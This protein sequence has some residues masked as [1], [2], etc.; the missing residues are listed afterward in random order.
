MMISRKIEGT[1]RA[2][3]F[4]ACLAV[5]GLFAG[6]TWGQ[7]LS[8]TI[9][10][11]VKDSS[12]AV[13]AGATV[14]VKSLESGQTRTVESETSGDY[15]T[16]ALPVG[17]YQVSAEKMGFKMEI[18]QGITLVVG[19]QAVVNF[20]LEVGNVQQEVTVTA[21]AP[22]INT[23]TSSTSGLVDEQQVKDL[24]L[25]GRSF[26]QLLTLNAGVVNFNA[27]Q[28]IGNAT[29]SASL[30]TVS[31]RRWEENRYLMNGIDYI[32]SDMQGAA[33][34]PF[35]SSGKLLG[36]DAIRE[37]NV[38][39]DAYGA[40]VGKRAGGQVEIATMSGTN[41]LH[42]D[43]FEFVRNNIFDAR[44][45]FDQTASAPPYKRNQ[46]G[47]AL[48]GPIKKDKL[49]VFG[50]YEGYRE[51]VAVST[52]AVVPDLQVR[53]GKL[54]DPATGVYTQLPA[55]P[56]GKPG[57]SGKC[58]FPG[59]AAVMNAYWPVPNG[60]EVMAS[61][62]I[63]PN[64]QVPFG[65]AHYF[66][67]PPFPIRE[68]F[69]LV[70]VDYV[71]SAKDTLSGNLLFD[72]GESDPPGKDPLSFA[73][74]PQRSMLPSL[75]ETHIFSTNLINVANFGVSRGWQTQTNIPVNPASFKSIECITGGPAGAGY[76]CKITVGASTSVNSGTNLITGIINALA[77]HQARNFFNGTDDVHYN[78][79]IH[80]LSFG[81]WIERVQD[82]Y[83]GGSP[84]LSVAYAD[85]PHLV[86][87]SPRASNGL[88]INP[89]PT[90]Q[91]ARS[92]EA[93]WYVQD[94][95]KVRSNLNVRLGLRDEMTNS[96]NEAHG[97]IS[98]YFT[99]PGTFLGQTIPIPQTLPY[100][101]KSPI[102]SN[103]ATAL[104]APRIGL[105]WD[106]TGK[107]TTSVRAGYGIY[108]DLQ[109]ALLQDGI[110]TAWPFNGS[111]ILSGAPNNLGYLTA[112]PINLPAQAA[113]GIAP[114]CTTL[115]SPNLPAGCVLYALVGVDPN[116]KTPTVQQW[117]LTVERQLMKDLVLSVGYLGSQSYHGSNLISTNNIP[118]QVCS[119]AA[120][121]S[122]G[123]AEVSASAPAALVPQGT[124][125][126]PAAG[127]VGST[128]TLNVPNPL[129]KAGQ[130]SLYNDV[131]S[132][133][134]LDVSLVRRATNGLTFKTSYT[135]SKILNTSTDGGL[136]EPPGI[137]DP[138]RLNL[139]KGPASFGVRHQF[140]GN[141]TY[142]LPFGKSQRFAGNAS[143]A[144]DKVIGGWQ[145]NGI[146]TALSG[147]PFTPLAGSNFSGNGDGSN[148]DVP[149]YNP[150]FKGPIITG[151][152]AN[153]Y[154]PNAFMVPTEPAS[155]ILGAPAGFVAPPIGTYGNVGRGSL[156]GPGLLAVDTSLFK[157][158]SLTE[159][160][161][162]Q[163]RAEFFNVINHPNF[164][165]PSS[166]AF[167]GNTPAGTA[168]IIAGTSTSSRQIQF[169]L[170]LNF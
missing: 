115:G 73:A 151:T 109:D 123:G 28:K 88:K 133:H 45:Y 136:N 87:D 50:N 80:A 11:T 30:F 2:F 117:N 99:Q 64:V 147:F 10:G 65:A 56:A 61:S 124:I 131:A 155:A 24:P 41:S 103:N 46:F 82:N 74:L 92:T 157:S 97:H 142:L 20:T 85:L 62:S 60:P 102:F 19:Q 58:W 63:N 86:A 29:Q 33:N 84:G 83:N 141:F 165:T 156:I 108:Y 12:G 39:T 158:I 52:N 126:I 150:F 79:G 7:T 1:R 40:E 168:G 145:W 44:N 132:Y 68:D 149:F 32:G 161:K 101:G 67:N 21:E 14:T 6:V 69:G 13:V 114:P 152:V 78:T 148:P 119:A 71:I 34:L 3:V 143:G 164:D 15:Q 112:T 26:D 98:N 47:G 130:V 135:Y 121:C 4:F 154:N 16:T 94:E 105:A 122:A 125:Y 49:F 70:R 66:A 153:W 100:I 140:S 53:Q 134:G 139:S 25:N 90:P 76:P 35:G 167:S 48:G 22:I 137:L 163:F 160:Y 127:P 106:V 91:Y 17:Q 77:T 72:D 159:R 107:G 31:G 129:L 166:S 43:V 55:C 113:K 169:A 138:A 75:Q 170:K 42:G 81:V 116:F 89:G 95:I 37:F 27:T 118:S 9:K 110:N 120:G 18:R 5:L 59:M 54:P 104:L 36:V 146:I 93:A 111:Q 128:T 38:L 96:F 51:R 57:S 23:T 144:M 162:L 8:S